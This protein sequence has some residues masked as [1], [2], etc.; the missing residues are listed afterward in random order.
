MNRREKDLAA[1][2]GMNILAM[3]S[4]KWVIIFGIGRALR[5]AAEKP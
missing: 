3:L 5:K 1:A 4:L 2:V